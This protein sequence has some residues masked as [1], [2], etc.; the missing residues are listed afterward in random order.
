MFD[1]FFNLPSWCPPGHPRHR[2]RHLD[3]RPLL[4]APGKVS[5]V[6]HLRRADLERDDT[7]AT[8]DSY[9]YRLAKETVEPMGYLG[10]IWGDGC[11]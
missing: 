10:E 5:V 3:R 11:G 8:A 6:I 4:F 9:Y 1:V 2:G 7:R